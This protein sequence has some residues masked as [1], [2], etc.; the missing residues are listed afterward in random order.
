MFSA[1]S[2]ATTR[3]HHATRWRNR[4]AA[5]GAWTPVNETRQ[6]ANINATLRC[7]VRRSFY[8]GFLHSRRRGDELD[9]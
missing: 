5:R 4:I 7:F 3:V 6:S 1:G 2:N 9:P 8:G